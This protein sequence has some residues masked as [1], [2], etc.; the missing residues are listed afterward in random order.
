M[1]GGKEGG[2]WRVG[3]SKGMSKESEKTAI[4]KI[5]IT[6]EGYAND[7]EEVA[8]MKKKKEKKIVKI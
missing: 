6:K 1:E 4:I 2:E 8:K 5:R 7:D 3:M